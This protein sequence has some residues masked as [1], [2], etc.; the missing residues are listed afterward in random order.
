LFFALKG[1]RFDGNR[2]ALQA[3]DK[4]AAYAIV[5]DTSLPAYPRLWHVEEVLAALQTL[6][7]THRR[8]LKIPVIA[9]T[10][11]NGK[12]TTKE[13]LS[14]VLATR[15]KIGVTQGN[16][17]NHIGVPLTLLRM[18]VATQIGIVEMGANHPGEIAA[19][20]R[21]AE[22]EF[23]L[24]TNIGKAHLEGFGSLEGVQKTK[25]ELYD[26]LATHSGTA[27]YNADNAILSAMVAAR[28]LHTVRYGAKEDA[29]QLTP[30]D[31]SHPFLRFSLP[32][33]PR[34]ETRLIGA[35]NTDN[36]LAA[37]AVGRYFDIPAS[38]A[39]E[40]VNACAPENNR[41]QLI[42]TAHNSIIMDAYNANPSSMAAAIE[43]FVQLPSPNK[44]VILGDMLEL[45]ANAAAE[46]AAIIDLIA[47]S[48]LKNVWLVGRLFTQ[49]AQNR[50]RCF[51]S[52]DAVKACLAAAPL[53]G[54]TILVKGSRG[55]GLDRLADELGIN[56]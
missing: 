14:C 50:Y 35:Y 53:T 33:Y 10:G 43:N 52:V 31:T 22:P 41:S 23:G 13:L 48:S 30:T 45:G 16:L 11:T 9:I 21:I 38:A 29:V 17:N 20:C 8:T 24:I 56:N 18:D 19:L 55:I 15:Y 7:Q 12:T 39:A 47:H 34:I 46:H 42:R 32:G 25:G 51:E 2:F 4:G 40:A 44:T 27:F 49:A 26:F 37:L 6:A 54:V 5:D 3:L 36:V 28:N 1:E